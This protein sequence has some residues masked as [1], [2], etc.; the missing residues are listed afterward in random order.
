MQQL[1]EGNIELKPVKKK[2]KKAMKKNKNKNKRKN[3]STLRIPTT[4]NYQ[5]RK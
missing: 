2:I 3:K 4:T 5:Q 1:A